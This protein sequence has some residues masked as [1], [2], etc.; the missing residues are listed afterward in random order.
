MALHIKKSTGW[1]EASGFYVKKPSG[2]TVI[3]KG[4]VKKAT[5]WKQF[6]PLAGPNIDSPLEISRS[7]ATWPSTLTG[8]NYHWENAD[9]LTYKFQ[10]SLTDTT[11]DGAWTDLM[12]YTTILNPLLGSSNTKTFSITSANFSTTVR[13]KWFRFVVKAVDTANDLTTIAYSNTVN[14]SKSAIVGTPGTVVI[15]RESASSYTY[16][17][18]NNGTWS[19]TPAS[20]SYQWQ[21]LL[22]GNWT[23]I[24]GAIGISNDMRLFAGKDIRCNVSA[25][26]DLGA[27][28]EFPIT[29]NS[30]FVDFTGPSVTSFTAT[31]GV[32][33]IVYS[34]VV[35]SDNQSPTIKLK[36][37]QLLNDQTYLQTNLVNLTP[38][39]GTNVVQSISQPG[40]YRATLIASDG[41]NPDSSIV[42]DNLTVVTLNRTNISIEQTTTNLSGATNLTLSKIGAGSN[43]R[44]AI[45]W[46]NGSGVTYSDVY[47]S[48]NY[49]GDDLNKAVSGTN[50]FSLFSLSPITGNATITATVIQKALPQATISWN[51]SNAQSYR[52]IWRATPAGGGLNN[53]VDTAINGNSSDSSV[54]LI[55]NAASADVRVLQVIVY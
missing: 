6:W 47:W 21:E 4:F 55:I 41:I 45:A 17:V 22:N 2:W 48:G 14:I 23:P 32:S 29:S 40:T 42:V 50:Q 3:K 19:D 18:T 15:E 25:V 54:S 49:N 46:A 27:T 11:D 44:G 7:S 26:D 24:D 33:K 28:S 9:T 35:T 43:Q 34:Y 52:V 31:G 12:S 8:K 13:S 51:Q 53:Y 5:G 30:L 37:E 38:K 1:T 20:Y 10:S 36:I 16:T 39:T